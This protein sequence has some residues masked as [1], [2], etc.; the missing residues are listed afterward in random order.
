MRPLF[1]LAVAAV[2]SLL[3][4]GAF[5][6]V[7]QPLRA[8][9]EAKTAEG[10]E[11]ERL[12]RHVSALAALS[13]RDVDHPE[14]LDKAAQYV[15]AEL[16]AAGGRVSEQVYR[17]EHM[18]QRNEKK[19]LGPFRNVIAAFGPDTAERVVVGA[20]YDAY[21]PFPAADDNGSG[22]AALLELARLLGAKPPPL[23]VELVAYTLEEPP[24][25][26]T[27]NMGSARHALK[28]K[29]EGVKVRAMLSLET[30]GFFTDEPKSQGGPSILFRMMYPSKGDFISVVSDR[31]SA[32]LA[33]AVKRAM[34]GFGLPVYSVTAPSFIPGIDYSDHKN[35]WD[36]GWP[37]VMV[38]DTAFYR[39][40]NY[41]TAN[42]TPETLDYGRLARAAEGALAAVRAL[43][44]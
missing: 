15:A 18:S 41:H 36:Q 40:K 14:G 25:F 33:R 5:L 32:A 9:K 4:L 12:K 8:S 27:E 30:M 39:N 42:D 31:R 22:V 11:L 10:V 35:Y 7:R 44:R 37:A 6:F 29:N 21:G 16:Q 38:T 1:L 23:R 34:S 43:S 26:L 3:A 19:Q 2:L 28:L 20:H 17:F 13:P 24:H